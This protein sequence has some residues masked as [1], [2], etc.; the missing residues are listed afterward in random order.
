MMITSRYRKEA[1]ESRMA[2]ERKRIR[3]VGTTNNDHNRMW[4]NATTDN[5]HLINCE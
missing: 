4:T 1:V 2:G 3:L 5:T